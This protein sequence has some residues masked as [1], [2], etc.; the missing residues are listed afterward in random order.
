[1][2]GFPYTT[3]PAELPKSDQRLVSHFNKDYFQTSGTVGIAT[4]SLTS[5]NIFT[6]TGPG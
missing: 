1:M 6:S 5:Q 2:T 4:S 3:E